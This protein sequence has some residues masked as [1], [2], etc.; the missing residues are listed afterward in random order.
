VFLS[1]SLLAR[2]LPSASKLATKKVMS[3]FGDDEET[4]STKLS[5]SAFRAASPESSLDSN[6][7]GSEDSFAGQASVVAA[8]TVDSKSTR[9]LHPSVTKQLLQD[10]IASGGISAVVASTLISEKEEYYGD[11]GAQP[12]RAQKITNHISYW[13]RTPTAYKKK[14]QEHGLEETALLGLHSPQ[15]TPPRPTRSTPKRSTPKRKSN[16]APRDRPT[17]PRTTSR[18]NSVPRSISTPTVVPPPRIPRTPE[19]PASMA[20]NTTP[21]TVALR[22]RAATQNNIRVANTDYP[23]QNGGVVTVESLTEVPDLAGAHFRAG[24]ALSFNADLRYCMDK[25]RTWYRAFVHGPSE[26]I[27]QFPSMGFTPLFN[28]ALL[29]NGRIAAKDSDARHVQSETLHRNA[30]LA[31]KERQVLT[32]VLQFPNDVLNNTVFSPNIADNR[33]KGKI[34]PEVGADN[35]VTERAKVC[36]RIAIYDDDPPRITAPAVV[37]AENELLADLQAMNLNGAI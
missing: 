7:G 1:A 30:L 17:P 14:L 11:C 36:F 13:K 8:Q 37:S 34:I 28:S 9:G 18:T 19:I 32:M 12:K 10:I 27:L 16:S 2:L 4:Y 15:P 20:A 35:K 24:Y 33:I 29:T 23:E 26:V 31:D 25:D 22:L 21:T 3:T 6:E 5:L